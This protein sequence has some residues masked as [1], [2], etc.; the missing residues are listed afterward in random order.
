MRGHK[1][2]LVDLIRDGEGNGCR[3]SHPRGKREEGDE[4]RSKKRNCRERKE[5]RL[6]R[7]SSMGGCNRAPS[8]PLAPSSRSSG[9][10]REETLD[11]LEI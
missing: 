8:G 3:P 9:L 7:N 2:S 6:I 5:D 11:K 1:V 10:P 4:K